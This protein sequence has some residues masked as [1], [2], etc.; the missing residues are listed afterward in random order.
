MIF[1]QIIYSRTIGAL[2]AKGEYIFSLDND[3]KYFD[4]DVIENIYIRGKKECLDII[5]FL[6]VNIYNYTEEIIRM[7]N[8]YTF[9]YPYELYLEQPELSLWMIKFNGKFLVHNNNASFSKF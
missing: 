2:K 1:P 6:N 3:D 7:K 4:Y 9:Q 5:H 8:I